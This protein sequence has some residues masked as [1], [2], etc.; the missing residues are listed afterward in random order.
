VLA[1]HTA[2]VRVPVR[3]CCSDEPGDHAL[4]RSCRGLSTKIHAAPDGRGRPLVILLTTGPPG[5]AP[6]MLPLLTARRVER[7]IG[8]LRTRHN[9][10]L[11]DTAYSSRA[12]RAHLRKRGITN[13]I[14]NPTTRK[15]T[16]NDAAQPADGRHLRP[17][18]LP[19]SM[20]AVLKPSDVNLRTVSFGAW[21]SARPSI[22]KR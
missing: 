13:V 5:D 16:A 6:L 19:Q 18:R 11:T 8:R 7:R 17:R 4:G 2:T 20:P 22:Q 3:W 9:R 14:P 12:I 1:D 15:P 10:V 21:S